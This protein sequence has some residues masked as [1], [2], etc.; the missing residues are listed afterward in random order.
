LLVSWILWGSAGAQAGGVLTAAGTTLIPI[1]GYP[2]PP[3]FWEVPISSP[4]LWAS[5]AA[6]PTSSGIP[7]VATF[8]GPNPDPNV[9][10]VSIAWGDATPIAPGSIQSDGDGGFWALGAYTYLAVGTYL[11]SVVISDSDGGSTSAQ[12]TAFVLNDLIAIGVATVSAVEGT[13]FSGS[14]AAFTGPSPR[15]SNYSASIDWGDGVTSAGRVIPGVAPDFDV[16]GVHAY[17]SEGT[18]TIGVTVTSFGED[19]NQPPERSSGIGTATVSDAPL[20]GTDGGAFQAFQDVPY[21]GVV[22]AFRDADPYGTWGDYAASID[23]GDGEGGSAGRI[24]PV[25]GGFAVMG[26]HTY[27]QQGSFAIGV[28]IVDG[29][30]SSTFAGSTAEVVQALDAGPPPDGGPDDAGLTWLG[31]DGGALLFGD[32]GTNATGGCACGSRPGPA[33]GSEL[34]FGAALLFACV[35]CR[36]QPR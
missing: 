26:T 35:A 18:F 27:R 1:V 10:S 32:G 15:A 33:S 14:V 8:T 13:P 7:I 19:R 4:P 36:R 21:S 28:A 22:A 31:S 20:T 34:L 17:A 24:A 9:Y 3:L 5:L 2:F 16:L 30:G 25:N 11:V 23:W 12:S 6:T 29:A